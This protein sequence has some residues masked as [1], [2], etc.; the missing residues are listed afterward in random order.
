M[1]FYFF[2]IYNLKNALFLIYTKYTNKINF[3][4]NKIIFMYLIY[5]IIKL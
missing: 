2:V 5:K 4:F 3:N 1:I